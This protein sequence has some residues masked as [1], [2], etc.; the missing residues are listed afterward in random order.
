MRGWPGFAGASDVAGDDGDVR[1]GNEHADAWLEVSHD[2]TAGAGAFGKD[3]EAV[4]VGFQRL[5]ETEQAVGVRLVTPERSE[6][7]EAGRA[8]DSDSNAVD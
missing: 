8:S 1:A 4:V 5:A 3:E 7:E 2:A 6:I